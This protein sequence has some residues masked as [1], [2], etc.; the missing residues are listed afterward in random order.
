MKPIVN[1][2]KQVVAVHKKV[3]FFPI[4]RLEEGC[5]NTCACTIRNFKTKLKGFGHRFYY[6]ESANLFY[7]I[8]GSEKHW[9]GNKIRGFGLYAAGLANRRDSLAN[10]YSLNKLEFSE[11]DIVI[12]CGANYADLFLFLKT[13][14][15]S[16]NYITFEPGREEYSAIKLNA[17]YSNNNNLGLGNQNASRHFFVNNRD[18]DSSFIE[19]TSYKEVVDVATITLSSFI[20]N[21]KLEKIKLLKLEGEGFE[22]EILQGAEDVLHLIDYVAID[23]SYERG[24]AQEETFSY[25]T[26]FLLRNGFEM[27]AV[28]LQWGRALFKKVA[29]S[30][31]RSSV[32]SSPD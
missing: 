28:N 24:T 15:A 18:A 16:K 8:D 6:D 25:Q 31:C 7:V 12:D 21:N 11:L 1:Y 19:P 5:N 17:P 9:F 29:S 30:P 10:S 32:G 14:I 3:L 20:K 22:P 4:N 27:V 13:K 23:G 26:N 2:F